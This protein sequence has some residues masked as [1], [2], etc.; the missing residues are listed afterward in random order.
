MNRKTILLLAFVFVICGCSDEKP[1]SAD[2]FNEVILTVADAV[3]SHPITE[4]HV[5]V[6]I[7]GLDYLESLTDESGELS[8]DYLGGDLAAVGLALSKEGY[9]DKDTTMFFSELVNRVQIVLT[10]N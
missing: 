5:R 6:T 10:P 3:S 1:Y 8:F 4:V 2:R 7:S 9:Q